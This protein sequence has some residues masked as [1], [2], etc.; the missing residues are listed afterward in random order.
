MSN[1]LEDSVDIL[2]VFPGK[3]TNARIFRKSFEQVRAYFVLCGRL[4][5]W[6]II[7]KWNSNIR[8]FILE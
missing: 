7:D 1:S 6:N 2:E 5:D 8:N 3:T 4:F